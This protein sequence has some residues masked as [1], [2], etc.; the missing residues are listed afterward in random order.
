MTRIHIEPEQVYSFSRKLRSD[1]NTIN[2]IIAMIDLEIKNLNWDSNQRRQFIM[3]WD[4]QKSELVKY[5]ITLDDLS[6]QIHARA[7]RFEQVDRE[8][9]SSLERIRPVIDAIYHDIVTREGLLD[10]IARTQDRLEE[11]KAEMRTIAGEADLALKRELAALEKLK[12]TEAMR[13]VEEARRLLTEAGIEDG[14]WKSFLTWAIVTGDDMA[15]FL[16][17][18]AL[19]EYLESIEHGSNI[20][21]ES[22]IHATLTAIK[23]EAA[24]V[25]GA[26]WEAGEISTGITQA[27]MVKIRSLQSNQ[28]MKRFFEAQQNVDLIQQEIDILKDQLNQFPAN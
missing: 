22:S 23:H 8:C 3:N 11:A 1:A 25:F 27:V 10:Q 2:K 28:A 9:L 17:V 18:T 16:G 14:P 21:I 24:L 5:A 12:G 6:F 20:S 13:D 7:E 15:D 19:F 4:Q 26:G